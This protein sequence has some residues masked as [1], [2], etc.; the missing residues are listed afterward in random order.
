MKDTLPNEQNFG[1]GAINTQKRFKSYR[2]KAP[3]LIGQMSVRLSVHYVYYCHW[4]AMHPSARYSG[5][6]QGLWRDTFKKHEYL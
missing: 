6:A 5:S 3:V 2:S 1:W 4:V